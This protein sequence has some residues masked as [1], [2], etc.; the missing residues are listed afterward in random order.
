MVA[1]PEPLTLHALPLS[2]A[3]LWDDDATIRERVYSRERQS[4]DS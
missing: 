1:G 3:L 2:I 4:M